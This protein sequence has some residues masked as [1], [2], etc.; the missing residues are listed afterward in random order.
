MS[1]GG[2]WGSVGRCEP[3]WRA[4]APATQPLDSEEAGL[5]RCF[6]ERLDGRAFVA[7]TPTPGTTNI[8]P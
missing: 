3:G 2:P 7:F 6:L 8:C 5:S 1:R 4:S